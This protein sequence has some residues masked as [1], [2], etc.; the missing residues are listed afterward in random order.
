MIILAKENV[1]L[2][3][4]RGVTN[5]GIS[6]LVIKSK[7]VCTTPKYAININ[8]LITINKEKIWIQS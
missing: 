2:K 8:Y 6:G 3:C 1:F 4:F 5:K 7:L